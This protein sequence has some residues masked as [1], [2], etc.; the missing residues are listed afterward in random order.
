[1][2]KFKELIKDNDRVI[3]SVI[4]HLQINGHAE[5]LNQLREFSNHEIRETYNYIFN[6]S[7]NPKHKKEIAEQRLFL[8]S[9]MSHL[10]KENAI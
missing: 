3:E 10:K 1:M 5:T 2:S 9:F 7:Q 6:N 8:M 4:N